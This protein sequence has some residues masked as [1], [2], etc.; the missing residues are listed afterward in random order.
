MSED[1]FIIDEGAKEWLSHNL[2]VNIEDKY[3]NRDKDEL[4]KQVNDN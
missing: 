3:M 2:D 4:V 1:L